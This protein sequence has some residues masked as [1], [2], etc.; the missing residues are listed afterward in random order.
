MENEKSEQKSRT[1]S[2]SIPFM[3]DKLVTEFKERSG[4]PTWNAALWEITRAGLLVKLREQEELE[5]HIQSE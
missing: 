1:T 3:I 5:K 4:A 2:I